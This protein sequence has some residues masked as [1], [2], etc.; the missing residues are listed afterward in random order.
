MQIIETLKARPNRATTY[1]IALIY[2]GLEDRERALEWLRNAYDE[3]DP[4]MALRLNVDPALD[5]LRTDPR[6]KELLHRL[7]LVS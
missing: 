7:G 1:Q 4:L 5:R 6:F 3:S 2:A